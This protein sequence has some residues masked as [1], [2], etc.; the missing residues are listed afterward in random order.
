MDSDLRIAE[1]HLGRIMTSTGDGVQA[2]AGSHELRIRL[3]AGQRA[4]KSF[5]AERAEALQLDFFHYLPTDAIGEDANWPVI[6]Q[7]L[8]G[9]HS[10]QIDIFPAQTLARFPGLSERAHIDLIDTEAAV[11]T[12]RTAEDRGM[13]IHTAAPVRVSGHEGVLVG[14]IPSEPQ[15][16]FY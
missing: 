2:V 10:A 16:R 14:G 11:P 9:Q 8:A 12:D 1:Q 13:V 3:A 7:A 6:A 15:P 4:V 5:L